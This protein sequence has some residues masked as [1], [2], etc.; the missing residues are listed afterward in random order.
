[1]SIKNFEEIVEKQKDSF[2]ETIKWL[3]KKQSELEFDSSVIFLDK[4]GNEEIPSTVY[5]K[6][7]KYYLF[8]NVGGVGMIAR[9]VLEEGK[10]IV[11]ERILDEGEDG[12]KEVEELLIKVMDRLKDIDFFREL[13]ERSGISDW[14]SEKAKMENEKEELER[15]NERDELKK[16]LDD[17]RQKEIEEREKY[18]VIYK[19]GLEKISLLNINDKWDS[20]KENIEVGDFVI[21]YEKSFGGY[22][23]DGRTV[24]PIVIEDT[25]TNIEYVFNFYDEEPSISDVV[26]SAKNELKS[27]RWK[28]YN[29]YNKDV[30]IV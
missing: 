11:L 18:N 8:I 1:M 13:K 5:L 3:R 6:L 24:Y 7:S 20:E 9:V 23:T 30:Y 28:K 21:K 10:E 27:K 15:K 25:K 19:E 4:L 14:D 17:E 12:Y 16:R 26:E 29:N 2:K 22:Q